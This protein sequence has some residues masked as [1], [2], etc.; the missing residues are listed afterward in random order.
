LHHERSIVNNKQKSLHHKSSADTLKL[1]KL[2]RRDEE[3]EKTKENFDEHLQG[4]YF[5]AANAREN[6]DYE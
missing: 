6:V 5:R 2:S 3:H 1:Q 4:A